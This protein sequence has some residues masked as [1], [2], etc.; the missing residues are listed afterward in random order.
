MFKRK[1]SEKEVKFRARL[2]AKSFTQKQGIDYKETFSPVVRHSTLRLLFALS[3]KL[4][5]KICHLDLKTA[6]LN[7]ELN[8]EVFM[9]IP[10]GFKR[11]HTN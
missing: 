1:V 6:F 9:K 7:G 10:E 3:V 11:N 8:E 5:L 4:S 2:V